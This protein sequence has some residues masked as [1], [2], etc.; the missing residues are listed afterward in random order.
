MSPLLQGALQHSIWKESRRMEISPV[1]LSS[2]GIL[3]AGD[4]LGRRQLL[5]QPHLDLTLQG[6]EEEPDWCSSPGNPPASPTCRISTS[7]LAWAQRGV[8]SQAGDYWGQVWTSGEKGAYPLPG[9]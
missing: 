5:V 1:S 6:W 8:S 4:L 9:T 2:S 3:V 7:F